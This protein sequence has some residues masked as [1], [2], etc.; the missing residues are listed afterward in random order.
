MDYICR[1]NGMV[2]ELKTAW[3]SDLPLKQI[4]SGSN[5]ARITKT[6]ITNKDVSYFEIANYKPT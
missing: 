2:L 5:P 1:V 6:H 3:K 4:A